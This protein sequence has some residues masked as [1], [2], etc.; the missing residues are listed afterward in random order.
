[1][2]SHPPLSERIDALRNA[3]LDGRAMR[4]GVVR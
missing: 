2:M 1:M 4:E 3:P